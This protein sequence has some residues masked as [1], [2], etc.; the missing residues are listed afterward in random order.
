MLQG[1]IP[2]M[3]SEKFSL[4]SRL[5]AE[6][7]STQLEE[8]IQLHIQPKPKWLPAFIWWRLLRRVLNLHRF[9]R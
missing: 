1:G 9:V 6:D 2:P 5:V 4:V 3:K 8:T 7:L